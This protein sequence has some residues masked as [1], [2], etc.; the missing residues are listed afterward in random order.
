MD[1]RP[2]PSSVLP[3]ASRTTLAELSR[4]WRLFS[5]A[6]LFPLG[7]LSADPLQDW[8]RENGY[9]RAAGVVLLEQPVLD[10]SA[11]PA[12]RQ[13]LFHPAASS[14][15]RAV[16]V[17]LWPDL[18]RFLGR[19][20]GYNEADRL[21]WRVLAQLVDVPDFRAATSSAG[22]VADRFPVVPVTLFGL[23]SSEG[24]YHWQEPARGACPR[25]LESPPEAGTLRLAQAMFQGQP[26]PFDAVDPLRGGAT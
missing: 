12:A 25:L 17:D 11:L 20:G 24:L 2:A 21:F 8:E 22:M 26:R 5:L 16:R 4:H 10:F 14:C 9:R 3:T 23:D 1:P 6:P 18:F 15:L 13:R 7:R 19:L